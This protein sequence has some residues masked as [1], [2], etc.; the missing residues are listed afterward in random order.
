[1]MRPVLRSSCTRERRRWRVTA[2]P[3]SIAWIGLSDRCYSFRESRSGV[4]RGSG[5]HL[6]KPTNGPRH[7]SL[8]STDPE[9]LHA[10]CFR[11]RERT[12]GAHCQPVPASPTC[13]RA[14]RSGL[15]EPS[16]RA[17]RAGETRP[18]SGLLRRTAVGN[19]QAACAAGGGSDAP[20]SGRRTHPGEPSGQACSRR[21]SCVGEPLP[22]HVPPATRRAGCAS[23]GAFR[24]RAGHAHLFRGL[25]FRR[26]RR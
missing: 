26:R 9:G 4:R 22:R 17:R 10:A 19:D 23:S 16:G 13:D 21:A 8:S 2:V 20:A 11:W 3:A 18:T 7:E 1:M 15:R 14:A 5:A 24:G 6:G 12:A 25:R